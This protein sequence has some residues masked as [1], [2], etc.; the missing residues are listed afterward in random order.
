MHKLGALSVLSSTMLV[1]IVA[2]L[3]WRWALLRRGPTAP[4]SW[5]VRDG[6]MW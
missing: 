4:A 3:I 5:D 2:L 6:E 1:G